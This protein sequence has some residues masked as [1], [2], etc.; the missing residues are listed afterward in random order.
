MAGTLL[1][2]LV[3]MLL[4]TFRVF[5]FSQSRMSVRQSAIQSLHLLTREIENTVPE[6]M[7][8]SQLPTPDV[9]VALS[10]V[11]VEEFSSDGNFRWH[12]GFEIFYFDKT[13]EK[14]MWK[15]V[16]PGGYDFTLGP[17]AC[18]TQV[19]LAAQLVAVPK[20]QRVVAFNVHQLSIQTALPGDNQI[21][22]PLKISIDTRIEES[23]DPSRRSQTEIFH[24]ETMVTPLSRR[25]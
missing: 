18:L 5:L 7:T 12:D 21:T 4:P 16:R 8:L 2:L 3:G 1:G 24:L 17:P 15:R 14:L 10:L 6:S 19:D 20:E 13:A 11:Q 9:A 23:P 25:W 22:L